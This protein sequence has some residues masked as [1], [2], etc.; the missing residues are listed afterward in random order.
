MKT[1]LKYDANLTAPIHV[2]QKVGVVVVTAPQFPPLTVPV[3]AAQ[4]V[5]PVGIFGRMTN[6]IKRLWKK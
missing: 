5:A 4:S 3:F 1:Q 6:S 2:G